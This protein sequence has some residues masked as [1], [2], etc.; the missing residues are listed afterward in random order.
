LALLG[1]AL[2]W[3]L[4]GGSLTFD[5][6][7]DAAA[8]E[9]ADGSA[10]GLQAKKVLGSDV[11]ALLADRGAS[12]SGR[13]LDPSGKPIAGATACASSWSEELSTVQTRIPTCANTGPTGHY[14]LEGL[15][16][17]RY[18]VGASAPHHIPDR[19]DPPGNRNFVE[20]GKTP[21]ATGIDITLKPGGVEIR[22]V[23]RDVSGGEIEGAWV[24]AGETWR[25]GGG[26]GVGT[27]SD[28]KGEFSLWAKKGSLRVSATAEG[29][30]P[31]GE[32]GAAPGHYFEILLT[33]ESVLVG[34]VIAK[35]TGKPVEG[36]KVHARGSW[37][38][39]W[40]G[41]T[42]FT[43]ADG[44]FRIDRLEPGVYK[45]MAEVEGA[46]G[47]AES[48][49]HL[50]LA[51]TS[52]EV[53]IQVH[54]AATVTGR[55]VLAGS[56]DKEGCDMGWISLHD[57][58]AGLMRFSEL[59]EGG[60]VE[61][62][63]VLPGTYK[64]MPGCQNAVT[65]KDYPAV[66]VAEEDVHGLE[67]EVDPGLAIRGVVVDPK[68]E[69]A[70]EINVNAQMK[71]GDPRGQRPGAWSFTEKD[72]TFEL[73]GLLPGTYD[74]D[75]RVW[76]EDYVAPIEPTTVTLEAGQDLEGVRIELDASGSITGN[77]E[78]EQG[79]P[80]ANVQ[81]RA[82]GLER[83]WGNGTKTADDGTFEI[84]AVRPGEYRVTASQGWR[85][86]LRAPGKGDDDVQGELVRVASGDTTE[87]TLVLE[88]K[89]G[90]IRGQVVDEDGGPVP[91]AFLAAERESE[92]AA[93]SGDRA[94]MSVRWGWDRKPVLS[95]QDGRFEIEDL[96]PGKYT[97]HA[98]RKGGGEGIVEHVEVGADVTVRIEPTAKLA[99]TVKVKGGA[100]LDR[101]TVMVRERKKAVYRR[102]QCFK[103]GG[104]WSVDGL[105]AGTYEV[106][107]E[108]P[109][110]T[111]EKKG[112]E[113]AEN[114]Q[115]TDIVIELGGK[116]TIR[117]SVVDLETGEPVPGRQVQA[118][119]L[120][121][122]IRGFSIGDDGGSRVTD[123]QG[124][125]E[126][127]H[128][129]AG[130][131]RIMV[132]PQS[133]DFDDEYGVAWGVVAEAKAG[134]VTEI[135]P[136]KMVKRRTDRQ[137][138]GGDLGFKI[139]EGDAEKEFHEIP[140][141]VAFI[142]PGGPAAETDL[143]VGDIITAVDGHD[144]SGKN[145]YLYYGLTRVPEGTTLSFTLKRGATVEITAAKPL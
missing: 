45:P 42:T 125:Y 16:R 112:I 1:L 8:G 69:P 95:D 55:V 80:L 121:G 85:H 82:R 144:V 67:W 124:R 116:G 70:E 61:I 117:G 62:K 73:T 94:R 52:D 110:G 108:A 132:L 98:N 100:A 140:L 87:V 118:S 77:V 31:G 35:A 49:V 47:M 113:L 51:Q 34:K 4:A 68:G 135:P 111:G 142:R 29:Y 131:I 128:V 48:S 145:H 109:E 22:G 127:E 136:I 39:R 84:K 50:G 28:S 18:M 129:P 9:Q 56:K 134:E 96:A 101:F 99:G 72:G 30:A 38:D 88:R 7:R 126:V 37:D 64:V 66:E 119:S 65:R 15:F 21:E 104:K 53:V 13:V 71:G 24:N 130:K 106:H 75:V 74:L 91:D 20:L 6:E 14:R 79:E 133:F 123:A 11:Q 97:V 107:A 83:G 76:E 26:G 143:K 120:S 58:A 90:V 78:D 139:R 122:G 93:A 81:V 44:R 57:E 3:L 102:D 59:R 60:E 46:F 12:I 27:R 92:S 86:Q 43:D 33:P 2:Y 115:R 141:E 32:E 114:E 19:Y 89:D 63:A 40:G 41:D 54:R 25:W 10:Q 17:V 103:T 105:P 137:G 23:V 36:A 5:S 138:R